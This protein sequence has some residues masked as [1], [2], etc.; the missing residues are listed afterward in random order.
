MAINKVIYNE[1]TLIDV[2]PVDAGPQN[3]TRGKTYMDRTGTLQTGTAPVTLIYNVTLNASGDVSYADPTLTYSGV[4]AALAAGDNVLLRAAFEGSQIYAPAM[5]DVSSGPIK[6]VTEYIGSD[7]Q[8]RSVE[9]SLTAQDVLTAAH[10][11]IEIWY[12]KVQDIVAN[13]TNTLTYPSTKAVYDQFQRKPVEVWRAA[14]AASALKGIQSD[15]SANPSWQLTGLDMTPY[16]RIKIHAKCGQG[17]G[18]SAGN[19]TTAAMVLE[20]LLDSGA[21]IA[22]YNGNFCGSVIAQ[23]PNNDNRIATL[24]CAVSADKTSFAVLRQT[25]LYGTAATNNNDVNANVF[26]IEGYYD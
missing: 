15:L 25:N 26:L 1:T 12:Y 22:E 13:R 24:T 16:R 9:M 23:K 7:G 18:I 3:V 21:A 17:T 10:R 8:L 5:Q 2:T 20:M 6:F 19:S 14:D 4:S 11:Q